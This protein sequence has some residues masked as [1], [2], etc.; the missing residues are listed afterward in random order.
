MKTRYWILILGA[1]ALVL[2]GI[3]VWQ[4]F[5]GAR[6][7]TAEILVDGEVVK[8]VDLS[9]DQRFTVECPAGYNVVTVQDGAIAV[10]E[11]DCRGNDCVQTG[12]RRSGPPIV[13]LP[14]RLVIRFVEPSGLDGIAG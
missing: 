13:C 8:T 14:H 2:A 4:F 1:L 6:A 10:T 7:A 5:G 11:A 12:P 3:C 9:V